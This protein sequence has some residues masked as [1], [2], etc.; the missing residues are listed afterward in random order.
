[1]G[2]SLYEIDEALEKAFDQ[3]IDPDTG[4]IVDE[5]AYA[6]LDEL[7]LARDEKIETVL[8]Y[9]KSLDSFAESIKKEE[10]SLKKRRELIKKKADRL[11]KYTE[12]ILAGETFQ[13][14]KVSVSYRTNSSV[15]VLN[16]YEIPMEYTRFSEPTADKVAIKRAI[17]AGEDVPGARLIDSISMIVK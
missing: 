17:K 14:P 2:M 1:M 15:E 9:M 3:A 16:V 12:S 10:D 8:L 11:K 4:E 5:E 7:A 13:S 6:K